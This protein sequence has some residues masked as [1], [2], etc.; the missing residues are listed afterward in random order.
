VCLWHGATTISTI[1]MEN[2]CGK[3][4]YELGLFV[5][6]SACVI[7]RWVTRAPAQVLSPRWR[8]AVVAT[9]TKQP[10]RTGTSACCEPPR[11]CGVCGPTNPTP[12]FLRC[13]LSLWVTR[14]PAQVLSPRWRGAVVATWTKQPLRTGTV[15]SLAR[16]CC[17]DLDQAASPHRF[18]GSRRKGARS[19]D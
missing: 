9:W 3:S 17:C 6:L 1:S 13:F 11:V 10:L 19:T 8:G 12:N 14:A 5:S 7:P 2:A 15:A 4:D 16:C 18:R